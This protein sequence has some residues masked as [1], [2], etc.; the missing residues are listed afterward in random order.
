MDNNEATQEQ[1]DN[2]ANGQLQ[3]MFG[4]TIESA[5]EIVRELTAR[6]KRKE[7]TWYIAAGIAAL[8]VAA[9]GE[10]AAIV[11]VPVVLVIVF[12]GF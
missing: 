1:A 11:F 5:D 7:Y 8:V 12:V 3:A 4:E 6:K 2:V 9:A 10:A